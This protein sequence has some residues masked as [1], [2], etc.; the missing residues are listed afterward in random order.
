MVSLSERLASDLKNMN[1]TDEEFN[2]TVLLLTTLQST[3]Q[4][5]TF[6]ASTQQAAKG[7]QVRL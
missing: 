2:E 4:H 5:K 1:L 6:N 3:W 7:I